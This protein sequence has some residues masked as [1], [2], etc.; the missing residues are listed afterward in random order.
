[1]IGNLS[2]RNITE[3]NWYE[4][5]SSACNDEYEFKYESEMMCC[6]IYVIH[7]DEQGYELHF[8]CIQWDFESNDFIICKSPNLNDVLEKLNDKTL[9]NL[10]YKHVYLLLEGVVERLVTIDEG[11]TRIVPMLLDFYGGKEDKDDNNSKEV[12]PLYKYDNIEILVI[13]SS[14]VIPHSEKYSPFAA[15]EQR[16]FVCN[17]PTK[18]KKIRI[19]R[20]ENHSPNLLVE[21]GVIYS[22]DKSRLIYCFEEKTSFVIPQTVTTIELFAFC[23]Q[24][25]LEKIVLHNEI[26][27]IGDSAFLACCSLKEVVI[28]KQVKRISWNCF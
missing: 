25:K 7:D 22:A 11:F 21:D 8:V 13:S 5:Y 16:S 15:H 12:F 9:V 20:I 1:M 26:I 23:H 6:K 3:R 10:L 14:I 4:H 27:S 19:S 24:T 2:K 28:P 17:W 18:C